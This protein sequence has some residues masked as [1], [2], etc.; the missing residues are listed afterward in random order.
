MFAVGFF[1]LLSGG[2]RSASSQQP[3]ADS[4]ARFA[5]VMGAKIYY[6]DRGTGPVVVLIH[7]LGDEASVWKGSIDSLARHHR[8]IALDMIGFGHSDKPPFDYRPETLVDFLDGFLRA[9]HIDRVSLVGN[10][11][12]GQVAALYELEH[13]GTVDKLVLVDAGGYRVNPALMT[14]RMKQALRLSTR[15][16]YRYFSSLTFYDT[17]KYHPTE[18]FLDYAMSERVKRGDAY[19]IGKLADALIRNEDVLDNR[20]AGIHAPTLLV[21]GRFDRLV[22][23]A[24]AHRFE[25]EIKGARLVLLDKCGHLP[26]VE[27]P[28]DLNAALISFLGAESPQASP[29]SN[30]NRRMTASATG[31]FQVI[32]KPLTPY[33]SLPAAAVGR[34]SIEKEYHGDISGTGKG[35]MLS[36]GNPASG[37]AGY[38]AIEDVTATILGKKGTFALQHA[39][40]MDKGALSLAVSVVPGS[41]TGELAGISGT[42]NIIF[43]NGKHSYV[44]DYSLPA[45]R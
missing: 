30:K 28:A 39:G 25:R 22:P 4:S 26:Q 16:D 13:R 12:G 32:A 18:A 43:E 37:S 15:D 9:L 42:M 17:A 2:S 38:V 27:C 40:T 6:I 41:G 14:P 7:G 35:E 1:A 34:F 10:S 31:T 3:A 24:V 36:A 45:E 5:T 20:V 44:F 33:N 11:L 19:T 29:P 21:W 23:L 8:V